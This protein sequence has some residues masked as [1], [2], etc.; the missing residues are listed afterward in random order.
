MSPTYAR[1][2]LLPVRPLELL[3]KSAEEFDGL[4]LWVDRPWIDE[5]ERARKRGV[6]RAE[7]DRDHPAQ[8]VAHD[9][10]LS[11]PDRTTKRSHVVG[12]AGN[13]V[14]V[15]G[16]VASTHPTQV[17]GGDRVLPC[18]VLEL[19]PKRVL[20]Q[21]QPGTKRNSGSPLPARS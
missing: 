8:A 14:A 2:S 6:P 13:R 21:H 20:S 12:K 7:L 11:D 19:W 10:R 1:T 18:E 4:R 3:R 15:A 9:D 16:A 17:E 5:H